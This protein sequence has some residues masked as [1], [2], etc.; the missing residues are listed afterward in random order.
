M[1]AIKNFLTST[2]KE[3]TVTFLTDNSLVTPNDKGVVTLAQIRKALGAMSDE[4]LINLAVELGYD[5]SS[6]TQADA[7]IQDLGFDKDEV[8][9]ITAKDGTVITVVNAVYV[10][11]SSSGLSAMFEFT[12]GKITVSAAR[13]VEFAKAGGMTVGKRYPI[14]MDSIIPQQGAPGYYLGQAVQSGFDGIQA[15][16][17]AQA[18]RQA[19]LKIAL[20][21]MRDQGVSDAKIEEFLDNARQTKLIGLV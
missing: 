20:K 16:F 13:V 11:R 18:D 15:I 10:G 6:V 2:A 5:E 3:G 9:S 17:L 7:F 8:G 12:K 19:D 1:K 14:K 21:N 4:D